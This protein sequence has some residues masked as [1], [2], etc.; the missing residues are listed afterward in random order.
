[1]QGCFSTDILTFKPLNKLVITIAALALLV[2]CA[3]AGSAAAGPAEAGSSAGTSGVSATASGGGWKALPVLPGLKGAVG[4]SFMKD[5]ARSKRRGM[6]PR[7][8][9]KVGDSNTETVSVLYGLGCRKPRLDGRFRLKAVIARYNR[10]E[11]PNARAMADCTPW[12]SFS[13]RSAA[14][15]SGTFT[16]WSLTRDDTLPDAGYWTAPS[17]C[18]P[19]QTPLSCELLTTRP[20]YAFIMTGTN[21][22]GLDKGFDIPA[23]SQTTDRMKQLIDAVRKLGSIPIVSTLPPLLTSNAGPGAID[24]YNAAIV[25]AARITRTPVINLWRAL[26]APGMVNSG[27]EDG[28]LHLRTLAGGVT[29][30]LT[31]DPTTYQDSVNFTPQGLT[32]GSNRRNL[33]WLQT[34]AKLDRAAGVVDSG[35]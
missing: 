20:R 2:S 12:T 14:A 27:M 26:E 18:L 28:G 8:F 35:R 17:D 33:I 7:V 1:M 34:L 25:K 3:A 6:R 16:T 13:R 30:I 31:P 32:A 15:Q 21:D 22:F 23:A 29:P 5:L 24:P 10:V 19:E 11:L 9:A 4:T